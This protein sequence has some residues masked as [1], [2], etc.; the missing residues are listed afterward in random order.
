M[1]EKMLRLIEQVLNVPQGSLKPE[2]EIK[3]VPQWD[4]LASVMIL[5][6]L[7]EQLGVSI[8]LEKALEFTRVSD[9][10]ACAGE[11]E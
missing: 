11:D 10:L 2:T 4:S 1:K 9:Y 6:E 7:A 5:S 3:D 8:P